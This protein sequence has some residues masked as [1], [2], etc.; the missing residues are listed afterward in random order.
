RGFRRHVCERGR[1]GSGSASDRSAER[2][3]NRN[4]AIC[5]RSVVPVVFCGPGA[6]DNGMV[7]KKEGGFGMSTIIDPIIHDR[8]TH[9]IRRQR[10]WVLLRSLLIAMAVW[11]VAILVVTWIDAAWVLERG[12]RFLLTLTAYGLAA[13]VFMGLAF[14]RRSEQE[15]LRQAAI[16]LEG[17][18]PEMR[19]RLLSAVELADAAE[20]HRPAGSRAFI[21]AAQRDV[22]GKIRRL[23][24]REL[25]PLRLLR[26]P[27]LVTSLL[28]AG[29]ASLVLF[30][31]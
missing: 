13:A 20:H 24:I 3:A 28:L 6:A 29:A 11:I 1:G 9:Y 23:D 18:R 27:L 30:P 15:K 31:D 8:L 16:A 5:D 26:K 10:R 7:V 17:A 25:L 12:T 2:R 21:Q 14:V 19:D 4:P 22:A